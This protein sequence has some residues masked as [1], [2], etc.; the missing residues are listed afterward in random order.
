MPH[1]FKP[2]STAEVDATAA[3]EMKSKETGDMK[4]E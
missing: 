4:R 3:A 1:G 2:K